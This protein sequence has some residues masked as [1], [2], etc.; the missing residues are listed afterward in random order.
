MGE[1]FRTDVPLALLLQLVIA[2]HA[3]CVKGLFDV[4]G[5]DKIQGLRFT[6]ALCA[7]RPDA[8]KAIGLQFRLDGGAVGTIP[9][10]KIEDVL[11]VMTDFV[12][13]NIGLGK[14][15]RSLKSVAK[16]LKERKIQVDLF[17]PWTVERAHRGLSES[18]GG[19][20]SSRKQYECR[21]TIR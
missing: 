17:V 2:N 21:R 9:A 8:G 10:R 16:F 6:S 14:I 15:S 13:D 3:G 20:H 18:A 1:S 12:R 19:L 4:A 5:L 7:N 11:H